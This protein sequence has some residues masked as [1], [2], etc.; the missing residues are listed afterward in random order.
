M[1][2]GIGQVG[3]V[4]VVVARVDQWI[5]KPDSGICD[6]IENYSKILP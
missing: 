2:E 6:K 4:G 1:A 5:K 3:V